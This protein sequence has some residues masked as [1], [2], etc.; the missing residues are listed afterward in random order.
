MKYKMILVLLVFSLG[1][2]I[3]YAQAVEPDPLIG[4]IDPFAG[5]V[6]LVSL[7]MSVSSNKKIEEQLSAILD[8]IEILETNMISINCNLFQLETEN[9]LTSFRQKADLYYASSGRERNLNEINGLASDIVDLRERMTD[10]NNLAS[11][12]PNLDQHKNFELY[13]QLMALDIGIKAEANRVDE[14]N[15]AVNH[16]FTEYTSLLNYDL[17]NGT[18]LAEAYIQ[19]IEDENKAL[20]NF[21]NQISLSLKMGVVFSQLI[22]LDSGVILNT[23]EDVSGSDFSEKYIEV[24]SAFYL[25]N[26]YYWNG[27]YIEYFTDRLSGEESGY[28]KSEYLPYFDFLYVYFR[29]NYYDYNEAEYFYSESG[30]IDAYD[31]H[32]HEEYISYLKNNYEPMINV[33]KSWYA[34]LDE[35]YVTKPPY[36]ALIADADLEIYVDYRTIDTDSDGLTD[37]EEIKTYDTDINLA[38]SDGDGIDDYYEVNTAG[39]DPNQILDAGGDND[40]D[41]YTNLQEYLA[42]SDPNSASSNPETMMAAILVPIISLILN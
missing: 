5:A 19:N 34:L 38:D 20:I 23:W 7:A 4:S 37:L 28:V 21:Q 6:G 15:Y 32:K 12:C 42:L 11:N 29:Y 10:E 18:T 16:D 17:N 14:I 13:I 40:N 2:P 3:K 41:G 24:D 31:M 36:P 39:L 30:K 9:A 27:V 35:N 26:Y 8:R 1:N 25:K 33:V 22:S